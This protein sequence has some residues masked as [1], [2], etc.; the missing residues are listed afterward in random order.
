VK[1]CSLQ[2]ISIYRLNLKAIEQSLREVQLEFPKINEVLQSRRD[3][4]TDE[5]VRNMMTG[6]AFID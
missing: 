4:V 5:V 2:V 1:I 3:S 6:Y